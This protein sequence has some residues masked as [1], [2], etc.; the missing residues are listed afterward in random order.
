MHKYANY[1]S[2]DVT[3]N[4]LETVRDRRSVQID[5]L[6]KQRP[7]V[8]DKPTRRLRTDCTVYVRAVSCS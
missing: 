4:I 3:L 2:D 8:A 7:A 5:H 1:E 6:Q